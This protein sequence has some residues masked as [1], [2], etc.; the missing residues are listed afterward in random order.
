MV[1]RLLPATIAGR[2]I[3][4]GRQLGGERIL[5]EKIKSVP[6]PA[7][8]LERLGGYEVVNPGDDR[9]VPDSPRLRYA[10][11]ILFFDYLAGREK[12]RVTLALLPVSNDEAVICGLA[13]Q[14][15]GE[16]VRAVAVGASE[17]LSFS[18]YLYRKKNGD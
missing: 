2:E 13:G 15:A 14:S 9:F 8:W 11:G 10:D 18:G 5:A 16:T 1:L 17:A 3:I 6:V 7:K 12:S 4:K